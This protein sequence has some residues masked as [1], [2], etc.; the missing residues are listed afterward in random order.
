MTRE[1]LTTGW[2]DNISNRL[3]TLEHLMGESEIDKAIYRFLDNRVPEFQSDYDVLFQV[4][5]AVLNSPNTEGFGWSWTKNIV[6]PESFELPPVMFCNVSPSNRNVSGTLSANARNIT[7][8][9]FTVEVS[10]ISNNIADLPSG[11][12]ID[13]T[14]LAIGYAE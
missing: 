8:N 2:F 3:A 1:V 4:G 6:F 5:E 7:S 10:F 14:W 9:S 13:L 11:L 12:S